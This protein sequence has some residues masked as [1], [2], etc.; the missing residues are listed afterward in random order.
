MYFNNT[1]INLPK[2][3][4]SLSK[5]AHFPHPKLIKFNHELSLS[6]GLDISSKSNDELA[7]IFVGETLLEGSEPI[8]LAYAAH[9]FGHFVDQLGDGRAILLGEILDPKGKIF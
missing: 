3:F 5:P 6:L 8:S 4:Y 9:Q 1:F 2:D 7:K